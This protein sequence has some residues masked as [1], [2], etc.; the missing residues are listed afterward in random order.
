MKTLLL[1]LLISNC[2]FAGA[3]RISKLDSKKIN[4]V[5]VSTKDPLTIVMP[6]DLLENGVT[7]GDITNDP[8]KLPASFYINYQSGG[9]IIDLRALKEKTATHINIINEKNEVYVIRLEQSQKLADSAVT[10]KEKDIGEITGD[11]NYSPLRLSAYLERSNSY[12]MLKLGESELIENSEEFGLNIEQSFANGIK[13]KVNNVI[14]WSSPHPNVVVFNATLTNTA[15]QDIFYDRHSFGLK[16]GTAVYKANIVM[17]SGV[18]PAGKSS[19]V[20]FGLS[21]KDYPQIMNIDL[22]KNKISYALTFIKEGEIPNS[23]LLLPLLPDY[24][25]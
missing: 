5:Y 11:A 10:Y 14:R 22:K 24:A 4:V 12:P 1:L 15:K 8:N 9:K 18:I 21:R 19:P 16:I 13:M 2:V 23:N 25:K 6:F 7:G 17:A 20:Q 3:I